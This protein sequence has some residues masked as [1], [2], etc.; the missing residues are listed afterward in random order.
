MLPSSASRDSGPLVQTP[1]PVPAT[2]QAEPHRRRLQEEL[3]EKSD[4]SESRP[5]VQPSVI[6]TADQ[7]HAQLDAA[8]SQA[9]GAAQP[10]PLRREG[11]EAA[12]ALAS[13]QPST[14]S[15]SV[16]EPTETGQ[17]TAPVEMQE[18]IGNLSDLAQPP[19]YSPAQLRP[20]TG[21][22]AAEEPTSPHREYVSPSRSDASEVSGSG[23]ATVTASTATQKQ[24]P[25]VGALEPG[26]E[27]PPLQLGSGR[28]LSEEPAAVTGDEPSPA[29]Q[30]P[31]DASELSRVGVTPQGD[32]QHQGTAL[33]AQGSPSSP[34]PQ[35]YDAGRGQSKPKE[36]QAFVTGDSSAGVQLGQETPGSQPESSPPDAARQE[37]P[38]LAV[39]ADPLALD[40]RMV[41]EG[42]LP[43]DSSPGQSVKA[44]A[45]S[46]R[47]GP[48]ESSNRSL[49]EPQ[50][51]DQQGLRL[52]KQCVLAPALCL[53]N[54]ADAKIGGTVILSW[55]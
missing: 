38:T 37:L 43:A 25:P 6:R 42:G 28:P 41:K 1:L 54:A 27:E 11:S 19:A 55:E 10:D 16:I 13:S 40:A 26:A 29:G 22:P 9:P 18:G 2:R 31:Q 7:D 14:A 39:A 21:D 48:P 20:D 8:G 15:D 44:P 32:R 30:D 36:A 46:S 33:A 53:R 51:S 34:S 47:E 12:A 52:A 5:E 4:L 24:G 3:P 50:L 23:Q 45:E 35:Q 49:T 17:R